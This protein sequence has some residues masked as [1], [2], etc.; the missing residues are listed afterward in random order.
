[1]TKK[2]LSNVP[3]SE[4]LS[5]VE[6]KKKRGSIKKK[7]G[8]KKLGLINNSKGKLNQTKVA[9]SKNKRSKGMLQFIHDMFYHSF[10]N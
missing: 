2:M 10:L 5:V 6:L 4:F 7:R 9:A 1:M 8:E 3:T